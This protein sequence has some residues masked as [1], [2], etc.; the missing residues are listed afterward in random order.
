[1]TFS[2]HHVAN[3]HEVYLIWIETHS[4]LSRVYTSLNIIFETKIC[5]LTSVKKSLFYAANFDL[6]VEVLIAIE[7]CA[8]R[9][10][11]VA[12]HLQNCIE[13]F[14]IIND[15]AENLSAIRS[16]WASDFCCAHHTDEDEPCKLGWIFFYK[17]KWHHSRYLKHAGWWLP[18]AN[19]RMHDQNVIVFIHECEY[20]IGSCR[21]ALPHRK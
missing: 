3:N 13:F 18:M 7:A 16:Y 10:I 6:L 15:V 5:L 11:C 4:R 2:N 8:N 20:W 1:M 14:V 21:C 17:S 9:H 12:S 19:S